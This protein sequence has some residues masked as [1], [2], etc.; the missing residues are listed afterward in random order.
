MS[1]PTGTAVVDLGLSGVTHED[2]DR[3]AAYLSRWTDDELRTKFGSR[4]K[5]ASDELIGL[6][7]ELQSTCGF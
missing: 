6:C 2:I 7:R 5:P 4:G 3:F 1:E